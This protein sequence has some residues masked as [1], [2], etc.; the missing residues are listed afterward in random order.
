MVVV[1]GFLA[2]GLGWVLV[3]G[4]EGPQAREC[5]GHG[6]VADFQLGANDGETDGKAVLRGE[7]A[8]G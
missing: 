4:D 7:G 8:G 1:V 2:R 3:D 5:G 6:A